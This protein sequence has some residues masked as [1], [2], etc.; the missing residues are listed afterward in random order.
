M[1]ELKE[2]FFHVRDLTK[3]YTMGEVEVHALR[4]VNMELYAGKLVFCLGLREAVVY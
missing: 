2:N 1:N 4:G 3:V